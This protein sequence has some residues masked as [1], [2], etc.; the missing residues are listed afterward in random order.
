[1]F[2]K[3]EAWIL[4]LTILTGLLFSIFFGLLV[5]QEIQA[6]QWMGM[7]NNG[8]TN[9]TF[10]F[11]S[12]TAV[13]LVEIP[14]NLKIILAGNKHIVKD[15]FP[16]VSGFVG[17]GTDEEMYLLLSRYDGDLEE[18][19]VELVDLRTFK[20]LHTWNPDI[21]LF[22]SLI[23]TSRKEFENLKRDNNNKRNLLS[24]PMFMDNGGLVIL[25]EPLR[26]INSCSDLVWQNDED[27]FHHSIE[28]DNEGN[29]WVPNHMYPP[30]IS[31]E[32]VGENYWDN[33]ITKVSQ[34]GEIIFQK[35]VSEIFMENNMEYL[36]FSLGKGGFNVDPIHLN[37]IQPV[38][39]D[40][41]FWKKGDLFMSLA[42]QSMVLLYRPSTNEILWKGVGHTYFQHDVDIL[43]DHRISIFSNNRK[44][45]I[46]G[47]VIDGNNEVVIYDFKTNQYTSYLKESMVKE[48]VRTSTQGLSQILDNGDLFVEETNYGR[49]LFFNAN[50]S[51]RWQHVNRANDGDVYNLSWSR[52]L[53]KS[54]S[55]ERVNKLLDSKKECVNE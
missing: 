34:D 38:N 3:L 18:G 52:I 49:T 37:D 53:Y 42:N 33:G 22:N 15:R 6:K 13:F 11:L 43:D 7:A 29:I 45:F 8:R 25:S 26:K 47:N 1:M 40:S 14:V 27:K 30:V 9:P 28:I 50:G 54:D 41:N 2:K 21:D 5:Y 10:P 51:L 16:E 39:E 20:I 19:V 12:K 44:K 32:K 24:S 4:Y 46:N 23:D 35:S 48:D 31:T 17:K 36:L 55:L